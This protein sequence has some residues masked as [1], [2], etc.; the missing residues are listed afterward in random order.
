VIALRIWN[1]RVLWGNQAYG[2]V[3]EGPYW[4]AGPAHAAAEVRAARRGL[5]LAIAPSLVVL[6]GIAGIGICL[7]ILW[8]PERQPREVLLFAAY[9]L[10]YAFAMSVGAWIMFGGESSFWYRW[11]YKQDVFVAY[12]VLA[13]AVTAVFRLPSLSRW[14]IASVFA[15]S[16]ALQYDPANAYHLAPWMLLAM[17]QCIRG[18]RASPRANLPF[19]VPALC[20]AVVPLNNIVPQPWRLLPRSIAV[21]GL[22]LSYTNLVQIVC[23]G[24][25]LLLLLRRLGEDR[26]EK[27]RLAGELEAARSVQQL[28]ISD[29]DA[30]LENCVIEAV[31]LP[32]QE[33]GGDLYCVLHCDN[34]GFTLVAGDVSGKG[35]RAA[36]LVS[37]IVG[38]LRDTRER[39]PAPLLQALNHV[40]M[41]QTGGGF[42]TCCCA[43]FS[44]DGVVLLANAG[45]LAPW[46]KGHQ[47]GVEAN[48]P[49]GITPDLMLE[50]STFLLRP[51]E[52]L[53]FVSDGVVE[54]A[55]AS[56]ELFGFDRTRDISGQSAQQIAQ[57]A[58]AWG[59]NDDITVV[60][61]RRV[62]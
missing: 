17:L 1:Q 6:F 56:G 11:V 35:L 46:C 40:A 49:L 7:L 48:L 20:L 41:G 14:T 62:A 61:V 36:L 54:A 18:I 16:L 2:L 37:M 15:A 32:A 28:L 21:S 22:T 52:Q 3:D 9:L 58:K 26:R 55:N 31:Y 53:T 39:R 42:V 24:A 57:A 13:F 38:A 47:V 4:V 51:G 29:A 34:G 30:P 45:H 43:Q 23:A 19:A 10:L 5:L 60:T 25:L 33:V 59:Q 50:E 8:L 44:P 27:Q 12:V